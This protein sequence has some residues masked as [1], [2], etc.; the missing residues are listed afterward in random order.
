MSDDPSATTAVVCF[1]FDGT[2]VDSEGRI[3]PRDVAILAGA[4]PVMFIPATGR[5]LHAV[6][7]ALGRHGLFLG[8]PISF[9]LVLENGA[10]VYDRQESVRARFPCDPAVAKALIG[11]MLDAPEIT[12]LLFCT[13]EVFVLWPSEPGRRM[14]DRFELET[15]P[16]SPETRGRELTKVVSIAAE[17]EALRAFSEHTSGLELER[18]FS[19]PTVLEFTGIGV[20][21]GTGLDALLR[22]RISHATIIAVGDGEND[23]PLFERAD[24]SFAPV[25]SPSEVKARADHVLDVGECGVLTP[26]L[27]AIGIDR[28]T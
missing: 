18:A 12:F 26:I 17:P 11:A 2:L 21:K 19:L 15:I 23:I 5:P 9:P 25:G 7:R 20:D 10:V 13:G 22:G 1:D 3:H 27:R 4:P 24:V 6:R 8:R 28:P 14:I 16:Y